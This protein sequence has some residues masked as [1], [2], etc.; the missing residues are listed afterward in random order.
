VAGLKLNRASSG[1]P[2]STIVLF[3]D[4]ASTYHS[5]GNADIYT[6]SGDWQYYASYGFA[7]GHAEPRTYRNVAGYLAV[8]HRPIR[9]KWFGKEFVDAFP[10][11]YAQ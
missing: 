7:D 11:Q 6:K 1:Q 5:R 9:Q 3:H 8:I 10:E 2:A 4:R